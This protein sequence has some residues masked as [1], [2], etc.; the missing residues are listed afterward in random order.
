MSGFTEKECTVCDRCGASLAIVLV[1]FH[2]CRGSDKSKRPANVSID[3]WIEMN[4]QSAEFTDLISKILT[5]FEIKSVNSEDFEDETSIYETKKYYSDYPDK[6][7]S[8]EDK[9][10]KNKS[11]FE[12]TRNQLIILGIV[13]CTL[14]IASITWMIYLSLHK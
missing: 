11:N 12:L 3:R 1:Q 14:Q 10:I 5:D 13:G 9:E 8:N 6:K 4:K 7:Q 2:T